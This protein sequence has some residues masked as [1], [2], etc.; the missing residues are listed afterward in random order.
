[1]LKVP[2]VLAFVLCLMFFTISVAQTSPP[3]DIYKT[4]DPKYDVNYTS[5]SNLNLQ[6]KTVPTGQTQSSVNPSRQTIYDHSKHQVKTCC[7]EYKMGETTIHDSTT[8]ILCHDACKGF[9]V[10]FTLCQ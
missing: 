8:S 2:Y 4:S 5:G 10:S 6:P 9:C 1:M 3:S 7:C